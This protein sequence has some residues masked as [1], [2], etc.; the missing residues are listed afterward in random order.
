[1]G[2]LTQK[3]FL[4]RLQAL[5]RIDIMQV[6]NASE[7]LEWKSPIW[8]NVGLRERLIT[9]ANSQKEPVIMMDER[10]IFFLCVNCGEGYVFAG[11]IAIKQMDFIEQHQFFYEYGVKAGREQYICTIR[12][13]RILALAGVISAYCNGVVYDDLELIRVNDLDADI[14]E[15]L[16]ETKTK[17]AIE[18]EIEE[19]FHHTY[20]DERALLECVKAGRTEDALKLNMQMD[21]A[22][23]TMSK[24]EIEQ[25]RKLVTVAIALCTRAAIEGGVSPAE[26]Y[27]LSDYYM[28]KSDTCKTVPMLIACRNQAVK[29]LTNRVWKEHCERKHTA[30]VD[31]CID[32][33][34]KH[35]REKILLTDL[36]ESLGISTTYLSR[37]FAKEMGICY[38]EYLMKVRVESAAN[39]LMYS[40]INICEIGDYVNF[41]SQSYFGRVFKK[42]MNLTP[43]QYRDANK[44]KEFEV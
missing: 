13:S 21:E 3:D 40:N 23:G 9:R 29:D 14:E 25:W 37:L 19:K 16:Q 8:N 1:M 41:P 36:A 44:P 17:F 43:K 5:T 30:Y 31:R 12:F 28:Q 24:N 34:G 4:E 33:I 42:Y 22:T 27:L 35:Y 11:P 7:V 6:V 32:Y 2:K 15:H 38:Q 20:R 10:H 18:E 39:L 26:A